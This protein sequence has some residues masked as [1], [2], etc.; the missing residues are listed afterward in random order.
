M[1]ASEKCMM[2][3]AYNARTRC[4]Q[5]LRRVDFRRA[6]T[7]CMI[8]TAFIGS[9]LASMTIDEPQEDFLYPAHLPAQVSR[10]NDIVHI[11]LTALDLLLYGC[12]SQVPSCRPLRCQEA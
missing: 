5:Q 6:L 3:Y 9:A 1:S 2:C 10:A 12:C 4:S 8:V 11:T 7:H